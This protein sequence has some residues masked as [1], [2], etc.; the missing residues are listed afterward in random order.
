MSSVEYL[1]KSMPQESAHKIASFELGRILAMLAIIVLHSQV[2]LTYALVDEVPWVGYI[3]NQL[4][5]FAVPLFFLISGYLIQPKLDSTPAFTFIR[6]S[7][8]LVKIWLVWSVIC[9]VMPFNLHVVATDG[10]LAERMGYWSWLMQAPLN[11]LME[12]GLVHLWYIPGLLCALA[13]MTLCIHKHKVTLILPMALLLYVY[14]VL[15]GSYQEL[16]QLWT[17]FFTRNGPFFSLLMVTLGYWVRKNQF[18]LSLN[19]A[20]VLSALGLAVH[21]FEAYWLMGFDI[22]FNTHDFLFGT[23]LWAFGLFMALLAVPNF[24]RRIPNLFSASALILGVYVAHLPVVILMNNVAGMMQLA[25]MEKDLLVVI[26]TITLTIPLV[27][28]INKSKLR[29]LLLR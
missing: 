2:I 11:T 20:L 27:W 25:N 17:P 12:G 29:S 15:A 13:L 5:R 21:F 3:V 22:A 8:P 6:Y 23:P 16:T 4:C 10:Y 9:L 14:G 19:K 24:G 1:V 7:Q 26:G 28:A 18:S